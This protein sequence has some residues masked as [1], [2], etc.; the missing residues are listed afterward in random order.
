MSE[1]SRVRHYSWV[2]ALAAVVLLLSSV[3]TLSNAAQGGKPAVT[4]VVARIRYTTPIQ[5]APGGSYTPWVTVGSWTQTESS[6]NFLYGQFTSTSPSSCSDVNG[7]NDIYI[8]VRLDH[9]TID[10]P[11]GQ[12]ANVATLGATATKPIYF[13]QTNDVS[14]FEPGTPK[15]HTLEVRGLYDCVGPGGDAIID[16]VEIDVVGI[17]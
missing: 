4:G 2:V 5:V 16:S 14:I 7:N 8:E 10:P 6:L 15:V 12:G 13:V 3:A 11:A 17:G 1:S 9:G